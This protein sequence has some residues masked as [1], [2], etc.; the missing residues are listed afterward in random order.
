MGK[1]LYNENDAGNAVSSQEAGK[2]F[3][4]DIPGKPGMNFLVLVPSLET[5][6]LPTPLSPL[7]NMI[8]LPR[9]PN[10]AKRLQTVVA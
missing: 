7:L 2:L 8:L 9:A 6:S 3:D 1:K 4:I 10:W 5:Q